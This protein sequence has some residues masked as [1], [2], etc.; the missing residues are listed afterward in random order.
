MMWKEICGKEC[1]SCGISGGKCGRKNSGR[2]KIQVEEKI[3]QR[4]S[5]RN[6]RF[7][8]LSAKMGNTGSFDRY[9]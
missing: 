5:K 4:W 7:G 8:L 2:G 6:L 9:S 3:S 1:Q